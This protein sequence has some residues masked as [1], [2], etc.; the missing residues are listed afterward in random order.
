VLVKICG[1][2][3]PACARLAATCGA[4]AVGVNLV[5]SSKRFVTEDMAREIVRAVGQQ[6][7]VVG[8]V[9]DLP[10][11]EM[12]ALRERLGLHELQLH[13]SEPPDVLAGLLPRAYKAVRIGDAADAQAAA[14]AHWAGDVLLVDA[15]VEGQLGG[16]GA[17]FDWGL[18]RALCRARRIILAGGLTPENVATAIL[19]AAPFGVDVASGVEIDG[20]PRRKDERKM[21]AFVE[22]ARRGRDDPTTRGSS[23]RGP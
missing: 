13:G 11:Y 19:A 14:A 15:K 8:V 18:V 21:R 10:L 2:T 5:P 23:P 3:G 20:D 9:A 16:T 7:T 4:D 1:I 12:R 17:T 6:V 22:R